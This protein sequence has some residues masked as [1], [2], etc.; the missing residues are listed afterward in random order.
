[1]LK[2]DCIC[3]SLCFLEVKWSCRSQEEKVVEIMITINSAKSNVKR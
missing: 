2:Y 3:T 1:M